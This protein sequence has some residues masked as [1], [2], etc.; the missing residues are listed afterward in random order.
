[1]V[2]KGL[3]NSFVSFAQSWLGRPLPQGELVWVLEP[4]TWAQC[5]WAPSSP[6][7]NCVTNPKSDRL[8]FLH[9][10]GW[11]ANCSWLAD[12]LAF[13]QNAK[14]TLPKQRHLVTKMVLLWSGWPV[15]RCTPWAETSCGQVWYYFTF[16]SGWTS[17][18]CTPLARDFLWPSVILL[19]VSL[20][21][22]FEGK[23]GASSHGNSSSISIY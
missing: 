12:W 20:T 5:G 14:L 10:A 7:T 13:S 23:S 11:L 15:I 3:Q 1:M 18:R 2:Y 21:C 8:T 16:G 9:V 6:T 19:Q 22:L 17:V 4:G